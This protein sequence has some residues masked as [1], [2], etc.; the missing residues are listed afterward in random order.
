[1]NDASHHYKRVLIPVE[2]QQFID[3]IIDFINAH[4]WSPDVQFKI[5]HVV[6]STIFLPNM[7]GLP[8]SLPP[9]FYQEERESAH[10]LVN[11]VALRLES[12]SC[13]SVDCHVEEGMPKQVILSYARDWSAD[14]ILMASHGRHGLDRWLMGSISGAVADSAPCSIVIL[15]SRRAEAA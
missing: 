10:N 5:L 14:L 9:T 4:Q 13:K 8:V 12:I 1:M 3:V 7:T 15:H 6:D 11:S 2:D